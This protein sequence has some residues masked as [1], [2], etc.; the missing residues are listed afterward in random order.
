MV[1]RSVG[2]AVFPLFPVTITCVFCSREREEEVEEE[3]EEGEEEG[4][5]EE[6]D[7]EEEEAVI[8]RASH[9]L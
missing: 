3:K 8:L 9:N 1:L 7:G 6:E 2:V 4:E 5:G